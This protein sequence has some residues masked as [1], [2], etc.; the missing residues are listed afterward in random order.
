MG[1]STLKQRSPRIIVDRRSLVYERQGARA[2][3]FGLPERAN[4]SQAFCIP[5]E[6]VRTVWLAPRAARVKIAWI[7]DH[8]DPCDPA[9]LPEPAA[10]RAMIVSDLASSGYDVSRLRPPRRARGTAKP[11]A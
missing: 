2:A 11:G 9:Q 6:S 8:T 7:E 4:S 1:A 5:R 10:L 3:W